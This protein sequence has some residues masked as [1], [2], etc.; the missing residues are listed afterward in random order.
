VEDLCT[1]LLVLNRGRIV[2]QGSLDELRCRIGEGG[3][4][5]SLEELFFRLIEAV[6]PIANAIEAVPPYVAPG[7]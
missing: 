2:L 7:S 5:E 4:T 3:R 6:P 1:H